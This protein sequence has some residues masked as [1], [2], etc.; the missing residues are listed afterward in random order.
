MIRLHVAPVTPLTGPLALYGQATAHGL[1]LWAKYAANLPWGTDGEDG[2]EA[3][4]VFLHWR[5]FFA[6]LFS[7]PICR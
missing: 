4:L 3:R 1:A 7:T 2:N 5:V 6:S